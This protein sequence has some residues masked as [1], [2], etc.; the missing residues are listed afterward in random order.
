MLQLLNSAI[1]ALMQ[2]ETICNEWCKRKILQC[3]LVKNG[4]TDFIQATVVSKRDFSIELLSSKHSTMR[5]LGDG[6][7]LRET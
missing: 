2:P 1:V 3:M 5:G 7:L 4:K 6:K